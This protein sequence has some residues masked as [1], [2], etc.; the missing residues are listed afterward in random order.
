MLHAFQPPTIR[1][2][3]F[4]SD[5]VRLAIDWSTSAS[6][7][8]VIDPRLAAERTPEDPLRERRHGPRA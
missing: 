3:T 5:G 1:R 8:A 7:D 4:I 2:S 6:P